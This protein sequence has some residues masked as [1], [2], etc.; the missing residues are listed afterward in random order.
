MR[1][2]IKQSPAGVQ[3][4]RPAGDPVAHDDLRQQHELEVYKANLQVQQQAL[5]ESRHHL[6]YLVGK[7]TDLYDFA[8]VGYFSLDK[9][10]RIQEVNLCG[11]ALLGSER[12]RLVGQ[13]FLPY[14]PRSNRS[15][16]LTFLESVF[17][18]KDVPALEG[19]LKGAGLREV[20][21]DFKG[22]VRRGGASLAPYCR[23][24]V[25]VAT[26]ESVR[27]VED[28]ALRNKDLRDEIQRRMEVE[29]SLRLSQAR[30]EELLKQS[31]ELELRFRE[32]SRLVIHSQEEERKRISRE[33]HD[34]IAQILVGISF[35]LGALQQQV[36]A[37]PQVISE[38]I[39]VAQ[40]LVRDSVEAVR[41]FA[42]DLRPAVLDDLGLVPAL[43]SY[44]EEVGRHSGVKI[45]FAAFSGADRLDV[46]QRTVIFR[47]AQEALVNV[48]R[49]AQATRVEVVL[50]RG[51]G[52]ITLRINDD[53]R[54]FDAA[55][56]L[57]VRSRECIGLLGMRE[58][59]EMVGGI[60]RLV[61]SPGNGTRIELQIPMR[62]IKP[63][64][65]RGLQPRAAA[66]N[67]EPL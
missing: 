42:Q 9:K 65:T 21:A 2:K 45:R 49:H 8:P 40:G 35:H 4:D 50:R 31:K 53:G 58:R 66:I 17:G 14:V 34:E 33:L 51:G 67:R 59:A 64:R 44:L 60:F 48:L 11:A 57:R 39:R 55:K 24:S 61:T 29:S 56:T 16:F 15:G 41:R 18:G 12:V 47:I 3:L 30:L 52:G 20:R 32:L 37:G 5:M 43:R 28:L 54:G 13:S 36:H 10:A 63:Q 26:A 25:Q 62:P 19:L 23:L 6:E 1:R 7:Y 27:R 22:T 38:K 46:S